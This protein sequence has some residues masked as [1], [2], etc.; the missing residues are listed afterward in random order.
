ME[1]RIL[2]LKNLRHG[3]LVPLKIKKCGDGM[4]EHAKVTKFLSMIKEGPQGAGLDA[5]K[6]LVRGSQACMQ[7]LRMAINTLQ[8]ENTTQQTHR[9][10]A[11]SGTRALAAVDG[12][13]RNS[14]CGRGRGRG[15]DRDNGGCDRGGRN[16]NCN[17]NQHG[18]GGGRGRGGSRDHDGNVWSHFRDIS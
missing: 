16:R 2:V 7:H 8:T 17:R 18:R 4:S 12:G 6:T 15:R 1:R 3:L 9:L 14:N 11:I 10:T 5:C 13:G